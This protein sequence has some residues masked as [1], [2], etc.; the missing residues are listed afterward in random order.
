[1]TVQRWR[2]SRRVA[3]SLAAG[4]LLIAVPTARGRARVLD[5]VSFMTNWHAQAEQGGYYQ[6]QAAGLYQAAGLDVEIRTGGSQLNPTQLLVAG[7]V[8]ITMSSG[9]E[10]LLFVRDRMP[11]LCIGAIFQKDETLL[12]AHPD[13]GVDTLA[14]LKGRTILLSTESRIAWWPFI[15]AKYGL[16]DSQVRPY[17][18]NLQPFLANHALAQEGILGSEPFSLRQ[19]GVVPKTFLLYDE[20]YRDYG[21]TINVAR[22]TIE[23]RREV[24]QRFI[25]ASLEGWDQYLRN[26]ETSAANA[27]IQRDNPHANDALI[28]YGRRVMNDAGIVRSGD[29]TALG[30]GAMTETRWQQFYE[31]VS[32]VGVLPAGLDWRAAFDL[33]F[34]NKGIGRA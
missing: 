30:I 5:K 26:K 13:S 6:A 31:T 11:F 18:F 19:Q 17:T 32:S 23:Q 3:L 34:V 22:R 1:M 2:A 12:M 28:E 15:R 27:L 20:G 14:D 25:D 7:R 16:S 29:A 10:A 21:T 33:S 4:P 8:D 9:I 24:I